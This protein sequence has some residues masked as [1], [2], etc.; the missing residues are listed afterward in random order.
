MFGVGC[1]MLDVPSEKWLISAHDLPAHRGSR[2]ACGRAEADHILSA[3]GGRVDCADHWRRLYGVEPAAVWRDR[4][5]RRPWT[6]GR[7]HVR[8]AH[9]AEFGDGIERRPFFHI[10][11]RE[12]GETRGHARISVSHRS[13][14]LRRGARQAAGHLVT[15]RVWV[16]GHFSRAGHHAAAGRRGGDTVLENAPRPGERAVCFAGG[17]VVRVGAQPRF[18]KGAGGNAALAGAARVWRS[19]YR[20]DDGRGSEPRFPADL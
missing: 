2:T 18:A 9:V 15:V 6:D 8:R 1:W 4:V 10:G 3:G 5:V 12:R 13:A 7:P 20:R 14:R 16:G 17:W 19:D 11:L